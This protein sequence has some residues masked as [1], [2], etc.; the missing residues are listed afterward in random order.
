MLHAQTGEQTRASTT[1]EDG[2]SPTTGCR[3]D[4]VGDGMYAGD[5]GAELQRL[6]KLIRWKPIKRCD[7]RFVSCDRSISAT[8]LARLCASLELSTSSPVVT[9]RETCADRDGIHA[10]R[11]RGG[12]GLLSY[13]N[14]NRVKHIHTLNTESGLV[15]KLI[16]LDGVQPLANTLSPAS[17]TLFTTLCHLLAAIPDAEG[18]RT[19]LAPSIAVTLRTLLARAH[20][21]PQEPKDVM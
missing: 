18:E 4:F 20:A 21:N 16:A 2:A 1:R 11:L 7:G 17:A 19:R 8:S 13:C 6:W 9:I 12:G 10:V 3:Y 15:R 14:M 5:G